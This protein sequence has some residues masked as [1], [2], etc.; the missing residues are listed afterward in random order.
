MA[1][2][3]GPLIPQDVLSTIVAATIASEAT[4]IAERFTETPT[5]TSTPTST[6]TPTATSTL[7]NTTT[8]TPT[9]TQ[10]S[11]PVPVFGISS[12]DAPIYS[13]YGNDNQT[14]QVY[15]KGQEFPVIGWH[16]E[17]GEVW[18]LI[19]DDPNLPQRWIKDDASLTITPADYT[20]Y[21][22]ANVACRQ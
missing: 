20:T 5:V 9:P 6:H 16:V 7:T 13:C 11:T 15:P 19:R 17:A 18:L 8:F 4:R 21:A 1:A 3:F 12:I 10:S 2:T 22:V 14:K